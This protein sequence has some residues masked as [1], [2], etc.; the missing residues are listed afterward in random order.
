[1]KLH[2]IALALLLTLQG[3]GR[4]GQ[5][6]NA[7]GPDK[8]AITA[9]TFSSVRPEPGEIVRLSITVK[10]T[11]SVFIT[12]VKWSISHNSSVLAFNIRRD[13]APG[14]SFEAVTN[15]VAGPPGSS[16]RF[17]AA[18]DPDNTLTEDAR[19]RDNNTASKTVVVLGDQDNGPRGSR[20]EGWE[21]NQGLR[22]IV[23]GGHQALGGNIP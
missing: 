2:G 11:G 9:F 16:H 10:N 17:T 21:G 5:P 7:G 22:V 15:W 12:R 20:A 3:L 4:D 18:V 14:G 1:M 8:V 13:L 19:A 6:Q 23:L